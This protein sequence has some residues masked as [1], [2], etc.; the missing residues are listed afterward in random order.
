MADQQPPHPD[1]RTAIAQYVQTMSRLNDFT[2]VA[3]LHMQIMAVIP[4]AAHVARHANNPNPNAAPHPL[5][6]QQNLD[7][8]L[9]E[10]TTQFEEHL[11]DEDRDHFGMDDDEEEEEDEDEVVDD[12]DMGEDVGHQAQAQL[13]L[14]PPPQAIPQP[15][16]P[17][18]VAATSAAAPVTTTTPRHST[19]G[20]TYLDNALQLPI[21]QF[22]REFGI[23]QETFDYVVDRLHH[24][25]TFRRT[26]RKHQRTVAV[27]LATHLL[28]LRGLPT[29]V[30]ADRLGISEGCVILYRK[31]VLAAAEELGVDLNEVLLHHNP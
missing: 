5:F 27:Q 31:R 12:H 17:P 19:T 26:G 11:N 7:M 9:D 21:A 14:P 20:C 1:V 25:P 8:C 28:R 16:I 13:A 18:A 6:N 29:R 2:N 3:L 24:V 30:V 4:C 10:F 22:K 15:T 23:T